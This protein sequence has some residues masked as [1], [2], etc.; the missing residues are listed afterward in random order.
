VGLGKR[1]RSAATALTMAAAQH[2]KAQATYSELTAAL[3]ENHADVEDALA[4][5]RAGAGGGGV[6]PST[7]GAG[8]PAEAAVAAAAMKAVAAASA[9]APPFSS[10]GAGA[11][12]AAEGVLP[13]APADLDL[14]AFLRSNE[15]CYQLLYR[16]HAISL[17]GELL[18]PVALTD[19]ERK[20]IGHCAVM[21]L[22]K[23][24]AVA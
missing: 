6:P 11:V 21:A 23:L 19:E 7:P 8:A 12:P 4:Q 1:L 24:R 17:A 15:A 22:A 9:R 2:S 16:R 14:A 3:M 18:Q 10:G 20:A 13:P 5:H